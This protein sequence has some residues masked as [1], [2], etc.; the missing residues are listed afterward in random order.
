MWRGLDTQIT[1][2]KLK[3]NWVRTCQPSKSQLKIEE[4]RRIKSYKT[5]QFSTSF[6]CLF[7]LTM[8]KLYACFFPNTTPRSSLGC[9][10]KKTHQFIK[11]S[12]LFKQI[13][14]NKKKTFS[15]NLKKKKR[16]ASS[17]SIHFPQNARRFGLESFPFSATCCTTSSLR[18]QRLRLRGLVFF[19]VSRFFST[20]KKKKNREKK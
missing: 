17:K 14:K 16:R 2:L 10:S 20:E 9:L 8:Q 12:F 3:E 4:H 19:L 1:L 13:F 18:L 15:K 7:W 5:I 6:S 11:Q